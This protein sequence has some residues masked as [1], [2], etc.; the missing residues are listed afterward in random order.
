MRLRKK[1][2]AK[3][4]LEKDNRV[5]FNPTEF[6]G[7]WNECFGNAFPIH[8]ELGC[9]RGSFITQ[10][11]K[12]NP[13]IN[14]IAIDI[15]PELLVYVLRK[16]NENKLNNLRIIPL[17]IENIGNIFA[18]D[19]IEK[20]YINFCN[21]WPNKRHHKRRLTHP[22]FLK[23]YQSFLKENA[24]VWFKTDDESLFT[25]SLE[26]FQSQGF[27]E[28]FKTYNLQESDFEGNIM[29]E[30]EEKFL[31]QGIRIKSAQFSKV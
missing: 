5:I 17:Y 31:E 20:I 26:Y 11:A 1:P 14:Y 19:E 12:I 23:M 9:G 3:P 2:W 27:K 30:Y 22:N 10:L 18:P 24:E 16:T 21:P 4:E 6:Q 8:L 7:K 15:H 28:V 29:T 13:E 25:D